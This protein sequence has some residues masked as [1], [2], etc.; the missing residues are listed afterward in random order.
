MVDLNAT[1][2]V[3]DEGN[4]GLTEL[5]CPEPSTKRQGGLE[6]DV[7]NTKKQELPWKCLNISKGDLWI[8]DTLDPLKGIT[9]PG[10]LFTRIP[11]TSVLHLT[12]MTSLEVSQRLCQALLL[13]YQCQGGSLHRGDTRMSFSN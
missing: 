1:C 12:G 5:R 13:G 11:Q 7:K 10:V 8:A 9:H 4:Y 3:F 6:K 2:L